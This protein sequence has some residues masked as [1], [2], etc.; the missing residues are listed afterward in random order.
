MVIIVMPLLLCALNEMHIKI[1]FFS[2]ACGPASTNFFHKIG[3]PG[4]SCWVACDRGKVGS[5]IHRFA[6]L[7]GTAF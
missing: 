2:E 5:E 3:D 1:L 4:P 7:M 6:R